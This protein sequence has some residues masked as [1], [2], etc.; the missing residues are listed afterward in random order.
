MIDQVHVTG[1]RAEKDQTVD[2]GVGIEVVETKV[3]IKIQETRE[4]IQVLDIP[5]VCFVKLLETSK[6]QNILKKKGV[7]LNEVT[8]KNMSEQEKYQMFME[9]KTYMDAQDTTN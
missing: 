9:F 4:T 5:Q 6:L 3:E 7:A 2:I 1:Q 8:R